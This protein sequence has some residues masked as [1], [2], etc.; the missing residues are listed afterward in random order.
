[1]YVNVSLNSS[2]NEKCFRK[3]AVEKIITHVLCSV[4]LFRKSCRLLDNVGKYAR[5]KQ[6]TGDNIIRRMR[7]AR[8]VTRTTDTHSKYV[9]LIAFPRQ[10]WFRESASLLGYTCTACL[11]SVF[12]CLV[13]RRQLYRLTY[14]ET[15]PL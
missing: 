11:V 7:F 6:V 13:R 2:Y 15:R 4:T 14:T 12:F 10:Q 8:C 9:I 3:K 1:M 5:V